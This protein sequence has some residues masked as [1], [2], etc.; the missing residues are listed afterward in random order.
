VTISLLE[1]ALDQPDALRP[2]AVRS[3]S[4]ARSA[5]TTA[6]DLWGGAAAL[7]AVPTSASTLSLV[8]SSAA[9][10]AAGTGARTVRLEGLDASGAEQTEDVALNGVTPVASSALWLRV[11]AVYAL[12]AGSGGVNA[13]DITVTHTGAGAPI[14]FIATGDGRALM[15]AYSVPAGRVALVLALRAQGDD[16]VS[17]PEV[18]LYERA[19]IAGTAPVLRAVSKLLVDGRGVAIDFRAC[20]YIEGPADIFARAVSGVSARITAQLDVLLASA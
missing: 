20:P 15:A 10:A 19:G 12:T 2:H 8:S 13:G 5:I 6:A 18:T 17:S 11:N 7:R 4:G 9:D 16:V 14:A 1:A 3:V